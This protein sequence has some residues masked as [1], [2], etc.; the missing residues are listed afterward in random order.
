MVIETNNIIIK[1]F[2]ID[3]FP[4]YFFKFSDKKIALISVWES[5]KI[6]VG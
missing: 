4:K 2:L 3:I 6:F 1:Y 5:Y